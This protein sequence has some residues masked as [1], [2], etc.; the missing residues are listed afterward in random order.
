VDAG[1]EIKNEK[2]YQRKNSITA[3]KLCNGTD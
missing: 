1:K 3:L 2:K